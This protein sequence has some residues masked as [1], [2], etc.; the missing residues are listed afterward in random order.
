MREHTYAVE[1]SSLAEKQFQKI[2]DKKLKDQILEIIER[3]IARD[4]MIG[5]PLIFVFKGV[6]SYRAGRLRILY[7]PYT[8]R[9]VIVT[10]KIEHRKSVYRLN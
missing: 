9:L 5:K 6:R 7:K 10:L 3:E 1:W 4:P 2:R 8:D